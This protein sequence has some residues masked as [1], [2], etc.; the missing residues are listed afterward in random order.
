MTKTRRDLSDSD[1]K[2]RVVNKKQW[3]ELPWWFSG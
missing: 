1:K 2:I 3:A